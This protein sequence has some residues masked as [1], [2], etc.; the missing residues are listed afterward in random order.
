[1]K[2]AR[3]TVRPYR[4]RDCKMVVEI[5]A[6]RTVCCREFFCNTFRGVLRLPGAKC[7]VAE[8]G[9]KI[10]G[11]IVAGSGVIMTEV[12][13]LVVLRTARWREIA[14]ALLKALEGDVLPRGMECINLRVMS[15]DKDAL[16]LLRR[17]GYQAYAGVT[18]DMQMHKH[19]GGTAKIDP[20]S[21]QLT[22]SST[23][24]S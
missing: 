20:T 17:H 21:S 18:D 1:M 13:D 14:S 12:H 8:A 4:P 11:Y 15:G 5:Q 23:P 19:F 7:H 10:Q 22:S 9:G 16:A 2:R 24:R 6:E 3:L